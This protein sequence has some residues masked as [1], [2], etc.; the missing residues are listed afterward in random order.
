MEKAEELHL[1]IQDKVSQPLVEYEE[2]IE[3][4]NDKLTKN[5]VK[6][7]LEAGGKALG[8][9]SRKITKATKYLIKKCKNLQVGTRRDGKE[10]AR[11]TNL[12]SCRKVSDRREFNMDK[13]ENILRIGRNEKTTKRRL[14]TGRVICFL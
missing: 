7:A 9:D 11:L 1:K 2:E 12:I 14:R 8:G 5:V 13:I 6:A 10:L 3:G 4:S